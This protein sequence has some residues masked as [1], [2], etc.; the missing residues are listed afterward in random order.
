[1]TPEL[2]ST[3]VV[4][5]RRAVTQQWGKITGFSV[6]TIEDGNMKTVHFM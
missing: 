2:I 3:H 4:N 6:W 5:V 1:M